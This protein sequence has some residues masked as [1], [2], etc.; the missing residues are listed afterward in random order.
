MV[1]P[2]GAVS[3]PPVRP[4]LSRLASGF[5]LQA[6]VFT[7]TERAEELKAKLLLVGVPVTIESRVQV[8]PFASQKEADAA[9]QKIRNL[10]IESI[11]I[12]PRAGHH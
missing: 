12:P 11:L 2:P 9:R 1:T 6:G 4:V 7:N 3:N 8:G 10:G 5:V